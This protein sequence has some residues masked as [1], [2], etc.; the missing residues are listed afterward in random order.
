MGN[1]KE[2]KGNCLTTAM[3]ILPHTSMDEALDLALSLDIP[4][5]P[6]LPKYS[7]YEDMYVQIS[8]HF[9]GIRID[10]E[11]KRVRLDLA[12]FYD[13]LYEYVE[14]VEN[15]DYFR[16]SPK[17]SAVLDAFLERDL[18]GYHTVRGQTIGPI[19]YGLKITDDNL[20]PIIYYDEV[21]SLLFEFIVRKMN[22][23]YRQLKEK[24]KNAFVWVDEPGLEIIFGSFSG[25]S[26]DRAKAD[27]SDFLNSVEGP[28]GV[29]LCGNPDW[30]FLLSGLDLDILSVDSFS[31]GH[32]FT[33]YYGE[34]KAF[35]ESGSI[36]SWG[37]VPTLT[38]EINEENVDRLVARLEGLWDYLVG[39]GIDKKL[40]LERAWLAPARC[41]LVN[42]DGPASVE[43]AFGFLKEVSL[44]L[45]EK[46]NLA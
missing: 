38:E 9:P 14:N 7:F 33:R 22:V 43:K 10:E 40:I 32:I 31:W 3:G 42:A 44:N 21:K 8:E 24:N 30:S 27:F 13:R 18:S 20:M 45:R 41:C 1:Y 46:Y 36:I 6:Q 26:S 16:L 39:R 11:E 25:Y 35:L 15:E 23:Q 17:Y 34:V 29:H 4:F 37:I 5:W 2:L 12:E 19:S 28:R